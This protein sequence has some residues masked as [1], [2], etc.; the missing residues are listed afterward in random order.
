VEIVQ[1]VR[2]WRSVGADRTTR[3]IV[4]SAP[5]EGSTPGELNFYSSD[6]PDPDVRPRLRLTYVPRRG[7]GIP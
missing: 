6:A 1:L 2:A 5:Q 3:A 4:L 7:F